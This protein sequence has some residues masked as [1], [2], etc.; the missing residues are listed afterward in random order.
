MDLRVYMN[1]WANKLMYELRLTLRADH[2][3]HTTYMERELTTTEGLQQQQTV[4]DVRSSGIY[5]NIWIVAAFR[6][7]C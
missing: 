4:G 6:R 7:V 2:S 1:L 3:M 5:F